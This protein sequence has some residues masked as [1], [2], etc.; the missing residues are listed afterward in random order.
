L[1]SHKQLIQT[2]GASISACLFAASP[3]STAQMLKPQTE[4]DNPHANQITPIKVFS[5]LKA[6]L[7]QDLLLD[8]GFFVDGSV[9]RI[10]GGINSKPRSDST[11]TETFFL[12]STTDNSCIEGGAMSWITRPNATTHITQTSGSLG[13]KIKNTDQFNDPKLTKECAEF[14]VDTLQSV[15]GKP[16][17]IGEI[18]PK[19]Q[20]P[21]VHRNVVFGPKIHPLGNTDLIFDLSDLKVNRLLKAEVIGDGVVRRIGIQVN[22]K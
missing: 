22:T 7:M 11:E 1:I 17:D 9:P 21:I 14:N 18:F 20:P 10:I 6:S 12:F 13:F 16:K 8:K 4:K 15:F 3:I 5:E 19:G 2:L